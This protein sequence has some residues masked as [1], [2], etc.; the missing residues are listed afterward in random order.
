MTIGSV[1]R[2]VGSQ[3]CAWYVLRSQLL[4][5]PWSVVSRTRLKPALRDMRWPPAWP[6]LICERERARMHA[7]QREA[8]PAHAGAG[9]AR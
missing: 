5:T 2:F 7:G 9:D 4:N 6:S 3:A 8:V 1:S